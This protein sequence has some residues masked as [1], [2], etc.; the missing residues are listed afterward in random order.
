MNINPLPT[1]VRSCAR[2]A[3]TLIELLVVLAIIA[4]LAALLLPSIGRAQRQAKNVACLSNLRQLGIAVR[5]Y[6]EDRES[7]L[8]RAELLPSQPADPANPFPRICDVLVSEIGSS[9]TSAPVS[10]VFQCRADNKQRYEKEGS[11][12]EWN[13]ELN[14]RK[15]DE[16]RNAMLRLVTVEAVDGQPPVIVDTNKTLSF[17]PVTTPL[18]YDYDEFHPRPPHSGKNAVF[19]DGHAE[20]LEAMLR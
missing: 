13:T 18:L 17:P 1:P 9:G 4:V 2:L 3:F 6:A 7:V 10:R 19:M 16:T 5:T 20:S 14:G 15:L 11:S 8:P 12:Y